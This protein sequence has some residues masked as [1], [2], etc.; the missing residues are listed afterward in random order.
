MEKNPAYFNHLAHVIV[1]TT[2]SSATTTDSSEVDA[3]GWKQ[4]HAILKFGTTT[5]TSGTAT[6]SVIAS[7]TS[8]GT[9][10]A[11]TGATTAALTTDSGGQTSKTVSIPIRLVGKNPFLKIRVVTAGTVN[12]GAMNAHIVLGEPEEW[13]RPPQNGTAFDTAITFVE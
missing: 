5:G 7:D 13:E 12:T 4:A 11:I 8:G 6:V 1:A 2:V 3:R 10:A 9:Y